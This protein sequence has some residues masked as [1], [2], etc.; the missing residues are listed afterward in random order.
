MMADPETPERAVGLLE[1]IA[2]TALDDDY[3]VVRA[4]SAGPSREFNTVLTGV[5]LAVFA[6][7]VAIAAIQ[8]RSDRPAT[9]R[10]R[11]TLISDIGS[12]KELLAGREETADR[13]RS[14]VADLQSAVISIDPA[15]EEVRLLAADGQAKGPGVR[16]TAVPGSGLSGDITDRD[17]QILVNTFWY[18]GAEAISLNG[19]RIGT[20]T[21][22]HNAGGVIKVNYVAIGAPFDL[23]VIGDP[24]TLEDRF[25]DTP[26]GRLWEQRRSSAAIR[27]DVTG[28]D[29]L[30]VGAAPKD[31]LTIRHAKAIEG[32]A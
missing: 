6:L 23:E 14:Q 21:S 18:A 4:G 22:I 7:L 19:Q 17:L 2:D 25:D 20:T 9:E 31:R 1:Q 29:D 3:Y 13:L 12:R 26:T 8:T 32:G 24:E 28:S 27:F 11:A 30:S 15:L 16:V 10:E 5:V